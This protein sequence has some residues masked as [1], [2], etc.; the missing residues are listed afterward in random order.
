M[1]KSC[2]R[3]ICILMQLLFRSIHAMRL[4]PCNFPSL[5]SFE[6]GDNGEKRSGWCWIRITIMQSHQCRSLTFHGDLIVVSEKNRQRRRWRTLR[7][8]ENWRTCLAIWQWLMIPLCSEITT[9][10]SPEIL[11]QSSKLP[12]ISQRFHCAI[13]SLLI[14]ISAGCS[15]ADFWYEVHVWAN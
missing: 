13:L 12:R 2:S 9:R 5:S 1:N 3:K 15:K 8:I 10:R 14:I 4:F 7:L 11:K 6:S